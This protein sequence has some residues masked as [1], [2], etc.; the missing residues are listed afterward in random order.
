[1][2]ERGN[3]ASCASTPDPRVMITIAADDTRY[4][5]LSLLRDTPNSKAALRDN[6]VYVGRGGYFFSP[7]ESPSTYG[8]LFNYFV[9]YLEGSLFDWQV[10]DLMPSCT[11]GDL[12]FRYEV[13]D[14]NIVSILGQV[15]ASRDRV[16]DG[17]RITP[18][19]MTTTNGQVDAASTIGLVHA[20]R[21]SARAMLVDEDADSRFR[22]N[23]VRVVL[24]LFWSI[25]ASRLGG[26]ALGRE[27]GLSSVVV[28][29]MGA[30]GLCATLLGGMWLMI[31]GGTYGSIE[32][33]FAFLAGSVACY[34]AYRTSYGMGRGGRRWRAVWC[35]IAKWAN[36]PPEWRVEDTYV[37]GFDS[38]A[39]VGPGDDD[40]A[41]SK[42]L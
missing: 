9:Q 31:W 20:G 37:R 10:G 24:L 42:K 15:D 8:K 6:F 7:Y 11:A 27:M 40:K 25:P 23:I 39:R 18:R 32:S 33:I 3:Q 28:Q 21:R 41:R 16:E 4:E 12:R 30:L 13:Q 34:R 17:I 29:A 36:T 5:T 19:A 14:P 2:M 26:V 22:A 1:M 35:R 38:S